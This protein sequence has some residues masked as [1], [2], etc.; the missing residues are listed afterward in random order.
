MAGSQDAALLAYCPQG[1][2]R[3]LTRRA[4]DAFLRGSVYEWP[5]SRSNVFGALP[6]AM[7]SSEEARQA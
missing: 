2:R 3:T 6:G 4:A 5:G 1:L 7:R